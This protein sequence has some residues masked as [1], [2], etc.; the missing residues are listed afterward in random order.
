MERDRSQ[1]FAADEDPYRKDRLLRQEKEQLLSVLMNK[2]HADE[3][4]R[5][6]KSDS[7]HETRVQQIDRELEYHW[8]R[9][10]LA[11]AREGNP[12]AFGADKL[13]AAQRTVEHEL[14]RQGPAECSREGLKSDEPDQAKESNKRGWSDRDL[15]DLTFPARRDATSSAIEQVRAHAR[16]KRANEDERRRNR[17]R[18]DAANR[19]RR[20]GF[21]R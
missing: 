21:G 12:L 9:A 5:L 11:A 2:R 7:W 10:V 18:S 15:I 17:S 1:R 4:R 19:Y 8:A 13:Q 16:R 3:E 20:R 14:D 6:T